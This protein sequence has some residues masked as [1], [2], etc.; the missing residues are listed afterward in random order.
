[1]TRRSIGRRHVPLQ[2]KKLW[3][4]HFR[5]DRAADIAQDVVMGGVDE[6]GFSNRAMR[7]PNDYIPS[8]VAGRADRER[9]G[10]GVKPHQRTSRVEAD[11]LYGGSRNRRFHHGG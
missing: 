3:N 7:H 6:T 4:L 8:F 11:A 2:P 10:G 5:R 1:M 9:I